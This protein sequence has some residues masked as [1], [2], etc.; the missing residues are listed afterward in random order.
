MERGVEGQRREAHVTNKALWSDKSSVTRQRTHTS[1]I[2]CMGR[3][4]RGRRSRERKGALAPSKQTKGFWKNENKTK[5]KTKKRRRSS[6]SSNFWEVS[7]FFFFSFPLPCHFELVW[8]RFSSIF[9]VNSGGLA[10]RPPGAPTKAGP[11]RHRHPPPPR[12]CPPFVVVCLVRKEKGQ[13]RDLMYQ[14]NVKSCL[15]ACLHGPSR[16]PT[17][18]TKPTHTHHIFKIVNRRTH[19]T[20]SIKSQLF[21]R[22]TIDRYYRGFCLTT[23]KNERRRLHS[24]HVILNLDQT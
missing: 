20:R 16:F 9:A 7:L 23:S 17:P 14:R 11:P 6:F 2:T 13:K 1:H 19:G 18:R 24:P 15:L 10:K 3:I 8:A 12:H 22:G 4:E 5:K 21:Q